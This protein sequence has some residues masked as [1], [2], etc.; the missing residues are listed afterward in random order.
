MRQAIRNNILWIGVVLLVLG[1]ALPILTYPMGRDQGMYANIG[2]AILN[3]R[4][5]Y[6][7]MWDIKPPPIYYIYALG[8]ELFGATTAGVRM[9]DFAFVP[10]GMLGIYAIGL[11]M[12]GRR[13]GLLA[14]LIYGVF[15]FNEDF[16]SLTQNDSLVTIPMI[17]ASYAALRA[18]QSEAESRAGW[19]WA[20]GCG[21]LCGFTLWFKHYLAFFVGALVLHQVAVRWREQP[22]SRV[23]LAR[24]AIA[25]AAGGLLTGGSLLFYFW[26]QGMWQE[27]LIIAEGTAA[28]NARGRDYGAFLANMWDFFYFKWLVWSPMLVLAGLWLP[29]HLLQR[30]RGSNMEGTQQ[31]MSGWWLVFMW[32]LGGIAFLLVQ[33]LGFDTHW[34]PMLPPLALFAAATLNHIVQWLPK[35]SLQIVGYVLASVLLLAVLAATTWG[36]AWRF[37]AGLE[38]QVAYYNRFQANDLKPEQSLIVAD[39]L[40]QRVRQGDT[41]FVWGFRPEV[42]F[43]AGLRPATRY[44]AQFPLVAPWYP[45]AWQQDHVDQLWAALPPFVLVLEDDF[46]PWVT[47]V[48]ADSHTILQEYTELNNWLIFNYERVDEIGDFI[49]WQRKAQ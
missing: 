37:A 34:I 39:Y 40:Q 36:R 14:A 12:Q 22:V 25:F 4:T 2:V 18:A 20:F 38:D 45:Q 41:L 48:D 30:W 5:P 47:N 32:L 3:G 11:R 10:L 9:I 35:P 19:L 6:I 24:E 7:D 46:M 28:Y 27:M 13:L 49:I 33:G 31:R 29:V 44:Q 26:S 17:W 1:A 42:P 8:I 21:L 15:Y 43:M 16:P 23:G